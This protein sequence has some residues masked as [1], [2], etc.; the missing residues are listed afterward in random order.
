MK[1]G[2]TLLAHTNEKCRVEIRHKELDREDERRPSLA[3]I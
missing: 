2:D 1:F 3:K